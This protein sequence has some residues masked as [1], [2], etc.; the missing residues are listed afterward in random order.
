[1]SFGLIPEFIGRI[2]VQATLNELDEDALVDILVKPKNAL[3]KQYQKLLEM[4]G[5]KLK[6]TE[7]SL[8]LIA[9]E[10]IERKAGARG[11][12][13]ILEEIMLD[14]MYDLPTKTNVKECII[15]EEVVLRSQEPMLV[16]ENEAEWA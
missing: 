9:R 6:F 15:N 7:G 8:R 3:I 13:G 16:Y 12:R 2:P 1:M 10:A 11:L 5:V 14:L 4:D